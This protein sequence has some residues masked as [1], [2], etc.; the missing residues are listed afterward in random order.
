MATSDMRST[1]TALTPKVGHT[2][3]QNHPQP[4]STIRVDPIRQL[5]DVALLKKLLADQPRDHCI[6]IMGI[7]TNLRASDL[8]AIRVGDIRNLKV[9]DN[10]TLRE[11]KTSKLRRITINRAVHMSVQRLLITRPNAVDTDYLFASSRTGNRLT[12]STLNKKV[13]NWCRHINLP[14]N[15]GSHTLRKTWGYM[16]R[17]Q[18][19][20]DIPTLMTI[21]NHATQRQSLAYLCIQEADVQECYLKEI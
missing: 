2:Q 1:N 7:N 13:K 16:M 18:H 10:F 9:G 20:I 4:G 15:Y 19:G 8:L 3:A 11:K 6:F 14:G 17:T 21:F 5:K 12:V